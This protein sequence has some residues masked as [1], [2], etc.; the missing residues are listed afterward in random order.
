MDDRTK[1]VPAH[2]GP[3]VLPRSPFFS[4]LLR[5]AHNRPPR[6]AVRDDIAH[7]EATYLQL[8]TDV[9]ALRNRLRHD[10]RTSTQKILAGGEPVYIAILAAGGYEYAVAM[11][12]VLAFGGA[13]VPMSKFQIYRDGGL[14]MKK[15]T[16]A[17]VA[18]PP[19]EALYYA[20]KSRS[21]A[22]LAS[23]SAMSQGVELE[24]LIKAGDPTSTFC[25]LPIAPSTFTPVV[26][27]ADIMVSSDRY[28]DENAPGVVIFT[29]GTN[30]ANSWL[31]VMANQRFQAP[32]AHR[33]DL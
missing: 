3:Y 14:P 11:L 26:R 8:L 29:S 1:Y 10:L 5:F 33:K 2:D 31:R 18:L 25:C 9:L 27:A 15:L 16:S 7:A 28:L 4:R 12:A 21:I 30:L 20:R 32:P 22:V 13:C 24:K 6:L 23:S 19:K 17:A